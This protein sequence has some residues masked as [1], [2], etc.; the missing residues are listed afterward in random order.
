MYTG[1]LALL[2][3]KTTVIEKS[4]A[5]QLREIPVAIKYIIKYEGVALKTATTSGSV[6]SYS[7]VD[8]TGKPKAI[9]IGNFL[10]LDLGKENNVLNS[11]KQIT[12]LD[13]YTGITRKFQSDHGGEAFI[14]KDLLPLIRQL[15]SEDKWEPLNSLEELSVL[16]EE[17]KRLEARIKSLSEE[18]KSLKKASINQ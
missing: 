8:L 16:R 6:F 15:S 1:F 13:T 7:S 3:D 11:S 5:D 12:V 17:N 10:F 18:V 2:Y 9:E 14:T 4:T